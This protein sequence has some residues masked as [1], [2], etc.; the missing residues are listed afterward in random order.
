MVTE[1]FLSLIVTTSVGCCLSLARM[2]YK[3]KCKNIK[4]CGLTIE[5]DIVEE[6]KEFEFD[7]IHPPQQMESRSNLNDLV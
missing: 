3:S 1:V 4:L 2:C 7:R 6:R 5:R